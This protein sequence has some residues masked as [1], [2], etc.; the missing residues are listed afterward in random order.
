MLGKRQKG[1]YIRDG[2]G[3]LEAVEVVLFVRH[4]DLFDFLRRK[5]LTKGKEAKEQAL[6]TIFLEVS[7]KLKL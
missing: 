6:Q 4:L 3:V 2:H 7:E 5:V 1:S